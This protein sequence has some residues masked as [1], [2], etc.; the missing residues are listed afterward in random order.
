[1]GKRF[2]HK[3]L[4]MFLALAVI[5]TYM[6]FAS[7][8][9]DSNT[10]YAASYSGTLKQSPT[11]NKLSGKAVEI[12]VVRYNSKM[13]ST[14]EAYMETG[15]CIESGEGEPIHKFEIATKSN[16]VLVYCVEHGVAQRSDKLTAKKL[17]KSY[18]GTYFEK[19]YRQSLRNMQKVMMFAPVTGSTFSELK[20][21]G[22]KG[23]GNMNA[24]IAASQALIWECGQLMRTDKNFTL[25]ANGL[26]YQSYRYG[27]RTKAIP[28]KHF[29]N[30]LDEDAKSIYRFMEKEI[31]K[32]EKFDKSIASDKKS[33]P[34]PIGLGKIEN[35]PVTAEVPAG[36][37][38][39]EVYLAEETKKGEEKK[40][41]KSVAEIKYDKGQKKYIVTV[42]SAE[43][44]N[45]TLMVKH[46]G[47]AA[48]RAEQKFKEDKNLYQLY[49][50]E[51]ATSEAHTQ[52]MISG[53]E[54]PVVG[55][56]KLTEE[57][58][59]EPQAEYCVPPEVEFFPTLKIPFEKIDKN[60]G[61]DND[62]HTPMGDAHLNATYTLERQIAGGAWE[63]IQTIT[64]DEYG[65]AQ[66]FL[67]Q[68]FPDTAA[69]NQHLNA[70]GELTSCTHPIYAG[71]PP[72][73]VVYQHETPKTPTNKVWDVTVN[74]RV[75]EHRPDGRYIDPD[76]YAGS[77]EYTYHFYAESHDTCSH[78]LG[79]DSLPWTP[80]QYKVDF[81]TTRGDGG[82][83]TIGTTTEPWDDALCQDNTLTYDN[84]I[85]INDNF[86]G[87]LQLIKSNEKEDPFKDSAMGGADLN[88]SQKSLWTVKLVSGGLEGSPYVHLVSGTPKVLSGGT[89]EY[90]A[91]RDVGGYVVDPDHPIKV[92]TNGVLIIRDLPYGRYEVTETSADDP[93]YVLE[94]AFVD[95][96]E[97]NGNNGGKV[98]ETGL[99][100]G[101][102][103]G[104][105]N[106]I[107]G[108]ANGTGDY[109]NNRYDG[110][111]RDKIKTNKIKL[112]KVDS[113][114][115]K[116]IPLKGTKVF[117]RYKGNPD[118]TDEENQ[119]RYGD[120][121]TEVKGIY[122]RFLPNA[123][124]IDS[125]SKN[126]TFE[127]DENGESI[128][129]YELPY[130]KYE[131]LEWLLPDGYY[132]GEYGADGVAKNHNFGYIAEG[133]LTVDY[134][135]HGYGAT[136]AQ[137][138]I[139]DADGNKVKYQDKDKYS[140][141]KLSDMVT[142]IYT[143]DVTKQDDHVDGYFF[144]K[145]EY[146]ST[147]SD[148]DPTYDKT[149]YPYIKY[150][151]VAGV[152]NNSV[153]AKI[154]I[155]KEGEALVGFN[156][157]E[158]DGKTIFEP[159]FEMVS[160]IKD[161]VFGVFA[162][163]DE[164]LNDGGEGPKT[165]DSKTDEEIIIP[166]EKSTHLSNVVEA[167]KAFVGKLVNPK[168][169]NAANYETGSYE[170]DTGA[171]LWYML[172]RAAS[173][174]NV[175]RTLYLSPE[176]KDTTYLYAYETSDELYNYRW[177]VEVILQNQA[178]GRNVTKVNVT[179]T[180]SVK[181]GFTADIPTTKMTGSVGNNILDPI[182]SFI[183]AD[184]M[185]WSRKSS[186][187]VDERVYTFEADGK[188][189]VYADGTSY[190]DDQFIFGNDEAVDFGKYCPDRYLVKQ[191]VAYKLTNKDLVKE[192]RVIGTHQ[193]IETPGVD[194]DGDGNYDGPGDTPPTY[195]AVED[196]ATRTMFEWNNDCVFITPGKLGGTA[197]V[198]MNDSGE[199]RLA[200]IGYY[201]GGAFKTLNGA[202]QLVNADQNGNEN[203]E[204]TIP[205]GWNLVPF[206]GDAQD[207]PHY[208][209]IETTD[210][211]TGEIVRSVLL[212]DLTAWQNCDAAG[213]FKKAVVQVYEIKYTQ[214]PEDTNGFTA[215]WDG[216]AIAASVDQDT[217]VATTNITKQSPAIQEQIDVGL[218]YEQE[219]TGDMATFRT[220]PISAP[221]YFKWGDGARAEMFYRGGVCK[222]TITLPQSAVDHG[223]KEIVPSI[224][225]VKT[226]ANGKE[227]LKNLNWYDTLTPENPQAEF[228]QNTGL[229]N[230]MLVIAK[231]HYS[232]VAGEEAYYTIEITTNQTEAQALR[233][234]F[235]D[236]YTMDIYCA[237]TAAG[238]GVG[239]LD[240][241]N[242]YKT[243]RYTTSTLIEKITT[244]KDGKAVSKLLP[245]GEYI[246]RELESDDNYKNNGE[247]KLVTL[248]Y[249]DQFT[250][251]IW[252]S[253][254]FKNDYFSVEID[255]SKVLEKAFQSDTFA[256]P[257]TGEKV[258]F[259][260]YTGED[261]EA[262]ATGLLKVTKKKVKKD[263][264]IDTVTFTKENLGKALVSAKLPEGK[265]YFKEIETPTT[266]IL[267]DA[268]YPFFIREDDGDYSAKEVFAFTEDGI[269]GRLVQTGEG[270]VRTYITVESRFPMPSITIDGRVYVLDEGYPYAEKTDAQGN[271]T[272][273][274]NNGYVRIDVD[275]DFTEI[276]VDTVKGK[277]ADIT[278]P[279]GKVLHV[280]TEDNTYSYNL[281]GNEKKFIP[282]VSYTGYHAEY[283]EIWKRIM[284][285]DLNDYQRHFTLTGAGSDKT[286]VIADVTITHAA[287]KTVTTKEELKDPAKPELGYETINVEKGNLTP[288]GYQIF[289]HSAVLKVADSLAANIIPTQFE[290]TS[291]K[292][293]VTENLDAGGAI[294]LHT[295]D[296]VRFKTTKGAAVTVSMDKYGNV[297]CEIDNILANGFNDA[298][299]AVLTTDD[300]ASDTYRFAKN[301][302]LARQDTS[303]DR[304]MIKINSDN[305]DGFA[306][307]N[308]HV[309]LVKIKK[310]DK[311]N[312]NTTLSGA[313]FSIY[314]AKSTDDDDWKCEPGEL[315]GTFT[316]VADGTASMDLD[317][318]VY[319]W[320]ETKAPAGYKAEVGYHKFRIAKAEDPYIIEVENEKGNTPPGEPGSPDYY[321][322]I[323]KSDMENGQTLSGAEFEIYG[324]HKDENGNI[325]RDEK[326]YFKEKFVT[327]E[328]GK[329]LIRFTKAG[330]YFYHE[331]KAPA[332]YKCDGEYY[333]VEIGKDGK[334]VA[335]VDMVNEKNK[336][337]EI[338]TTAA[339]K[340]G[341]K[342]IEAAG[343]VTIVDTVSYFNLEVGKTYIMKGTLM[344]KETGK[345]LTVSGK[346]VTAE[347]TFTPKTK[348]GTVKL[349]F[350]F[351][352]AAIKD[353]SKLVVFEKCY[354]YD[355]KTKIAGK[356]IAKHTD[357]NDE[358]QTVI[359]KEKPEKPNKPE[360]PD[361]PNEV[362]KT[363]DQT[364]LCRWIALLG[365]AFLG[366]L[367]SML[368]LRSKQE[369][370]AEEKQ[371]GQKCA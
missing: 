301:V 50:W 41:D 327:G 154:E 318:G 216:F 131:I 293:T 266:H 222:T 75:T 128:I 188:E 146:D 145:V 124:Q 195:K 326:P 256:E 349:T 173:E 244:D 133:Q 114:T 26:Y 85:Y 12:H 39:G 299:N 367:L 89:F 328:Y 213:N 310:V 92:G 356:L 86:R 276:E 8:L 227:E 279:N 58:Q 341:E 357:I 232:T 275:K 6:P 354:E 56:L 165:F 150:Y 129:P 199:E 325:V 5:V 123:E 183:D 263:T 2:T 176:Q 306:I 111:I 23:S 264:L 46:N 338:R 278:L 34:T 239:V 156:K 288:N 82:A 217:G 359:I 117:I 315:I 90:T 180:T 262:N 130:G 307:E 1:M 60:G 9:G 36:S 204:Y 122:N 57:P 161:A 53:L 253:A 190:K 168:S 108:V 271:I 218:G 281:D 49:F 104:G 95:V 159:V 215:Q 87:D 100:G 291:G 249:K 18:Y 274:D 78:A 73:I 59:P 69:I 320:Q 362:P 200:A 81:S 141:E 157:V 285:E 13:D 333:E 61:W 369:D 116:N 162:A 101:Y 241:Y 337:P 118:Y 179:K 268:V 99:F 31:K 20:D 11:G 137:F 205:D 210:A 226:D 347:K 280:E 265:Y 153:K 138:G 360:K 4:S 22:Y 214:E 91:S 194:A 355:T 158:K 30:C 309:P 298:D 38:G 270:K 246:V 51:H 283:E 65:N 231:A 221:I 178:N 234:R 148:N 149:K 186:L 43:A 107:G 361:K 311:D 55:Y 105:T 316:T 272:P 185:D 136:V 151:K 172:E 277:A 364:D 135:Q 119:K 322:E 15:V 67:D 209:M 340:N 219:V 120:S 110:N 201:A 143:F 358:G 54:D 287:S 296:T 366:M 93:M 17:K 192:E 127:L 169:Y 37:Y 334:T 314:K 363:G 112:V 71:D 247:D 202:Y 286:D 62:Q 212:S 79:C 33:K 332:G 181:A 240:L 63:T 102:N 139:Y 98:N 260:L 193:E 295:K 321:L 68:P 77:R 170:H 242:V 235:A 64:L 106:V 350:T 32:Y 351:N 42:N 208:I 147:T 19:N 254:K 196:K 171:Q 339:G 184:E 250:P 198:R 40:I 282:T 261:I 48:K 28:A 191:Y 346:K 312:H 224:N 251:L 290:R 323:T 267:S 225:Y 52:G 142:N 164:T 269:T 25:K 47:A 182:T 88:I 197:F 83:Y 228:N 305:E 70:W 84:E 297:K 292:T 94:H 76:K 155:T 303:A 230:G 236:G 189:E 342:K 229:A 16:D 238:N 371:E 370:A 174:G 344:N 109:W 10:A 223:Y 302:T 284:G 257:N 21:L 304:M 24:W 289:N 329:V 203:V 7:M 125:K 211:G 352:A 160:Y 237:D 336:E 273:A 45:K 252:G 207:D 330:T 324:S 27:P 243:N 248:S 163:K 345:A 66:E 140:F 331:T 220:I 80:V 3:I 103:K 187:S 308:E 313:E 72:T 152:I 300:V 348:D 335:K 258:V 177:D 206:T 96:G 353:G 132:V 113:E 255:I 259:G 74:Y 44:L 134:N 365:L 29:Y 35:Y 368:S 166:K 97:H 294:V 233:L 343:K 167:V 144:Q 245:L 115:G 14:D 317:Y 319:F 121:G 175:K 126:Y